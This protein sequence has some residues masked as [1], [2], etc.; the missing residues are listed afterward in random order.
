MN[1]IPTSSFYGNSLKGYTP[2]AL[3]EDAKKLYRG[4]S[5]A[6]CFHFP[7]QSA[8]LE[9]AAKL[10]GLELFAEDLDSSGTR[11]YLLAS[12]SDFWE[13]YRKR[14]SKHFYEVIRENVSCKLYFDL[15]YIRAC[16]THVQEQVL[17]DSISKLVKEGLKQILKRKESSLLPYL[18]CLVLDS[19]SQEKFSKHIIFPKIVFP[20][21]RITGKFI[22]K[23]LQMSDISSHFLVLKP[24]R[25]EMQTVL[26]IDLSVY[27]RNR[28]FRI[29][30]S[31][32]M[33]EN[34]PL[35]IGQS[36]NQELL[37]ETLICY[38]YPDDVILIDEAQIDYIQPLNDS[39]EIPFTLKSSLLPNKYNDTFAT[40]N[41]KSSPFPEIDKFIES[42]I[43][44]RQVK[45]SIRNVL[46]FSSSLKLVYNIQK[47]RYC[48][49]I[50]RHHKSNHIVLIVELNTM[51][52]YQKCLDPE[53]RAIDYRSPPLP[54]PE[55]L[56]QNFPLK[57]DFEASK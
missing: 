7:T 21:N 40:S 8:A 56:L 22:S 57:T 15:E 11:H 4:L 28:C 53:C 19:S 5:T 10:P 41:S 3:R 16:N 18:K 17:V 47:Y 25:D 42:V 34:R 12:Y 31:S 14:T 49:H 38:F 29:L 43:Y 50:G 55:H 35:T 26:A 45:G 48:H 33:G 54:L 30:G 52:Y 32:K 39:F 23:L 51:V 37:H 13:I 2:P 46:F 1:R 36:M 9:A 6:K 20:N 24:S 44:D 27:S